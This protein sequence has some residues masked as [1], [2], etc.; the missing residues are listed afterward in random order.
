[1]KTGANQVVL[2]SNNQKERRKCPTRTISSNP[3]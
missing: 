1:M 2:A 3:V